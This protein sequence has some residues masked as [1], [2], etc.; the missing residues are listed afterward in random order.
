MPPVGYELE[1]LLS[2][3]GPERLGF[4]YD[5]GHAHALSYLGFFRHDEW[6]EW[7]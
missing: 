4:I 5:V 1:E 7:R 2:L 3:A 6:L